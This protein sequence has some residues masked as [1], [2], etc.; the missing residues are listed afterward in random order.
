MLT[1]LNAEMGGLI[2]DPR[3]QRSCHTQID[4]EQGLLGTL[5]PLL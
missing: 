2:Q 3:N 4:R 5:Y 1:L